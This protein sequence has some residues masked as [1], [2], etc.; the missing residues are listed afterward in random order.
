MQTDMDQQEPTETEGTYLNVPE[1]TQINRNRHK[2]TPTDMQCL[3]VNGAIIK[4]LNPYLHMT[5]FPYLSSPF[6]SVIPNLYYEGLRG[7]LFKNKI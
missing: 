6:N 1:P 2:P 3:C 5:L 4:F 7:I